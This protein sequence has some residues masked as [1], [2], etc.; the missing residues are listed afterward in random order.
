MLDQLLFGS[1][2]LML[3]VSL[4]LT[5]K[6]RFVQ[7]RKLP[8]MFSLFLNRKKG[9]DGTIC[10]R[11]ALFTAMSTTLGLSTM[12]APVIAIRLGGPGAVMGFFLATVLGA[13][14]SYTE[15]SFA[16]AYREKKEGKIHGGPMQDLQKA[17]SPF[18]AKWYAFFCGI[19]MMVWSAAQSNQ[20]AQL[21]SAKHVCLVYIPTWITG[22][23]LAIFVLIIL[24]GGIKRIASWSAK[25][26]PTMF[27]LYVGA[28]LFIIAL[29]IGK[30]PSIFH[31][32]WSSCFH[33]QSF[34]SG[35]VIGGLLSAFRWGILKGL[36]GNEAG[37]GTQT[38]PHSMAEVDEAT[39]QGIL[40]MA[41]TYC[42][43]VILILSSFVALITMTWMDPE[44][45]LGIEMVAVSFFNY[46]SYAGLVIVSISALLFA[47][48]T[49]LGNSY[50][51]SQCFLYLS[52]NHGIVFY[53][54][55]TAALIFWGAI[56]GVKSLWGN[57][58]FVLA[59]V[60]VP[61]ILSILWLSFRK[62]ES[63]STTTS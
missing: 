53:Y 6:T 49:I 37:I 24:I 32:I 43:G 19:L 20:L 44:L 25:L 1:G 46:F 35:I 40:S 15:V 9:R 10:S 42:A 54:L 52:K 2:I 45:N 26:V 56:A 28:A 34:G 23:V 30:L 63:L 58:D 31:L 17:I 8:Q 47:F 18:M 11:R 12:V 59:L 48:G 27:L 50:N 5:I 21:L 38:I 55:L 4:I 41:S 14:V 33:P 3:T 62:Q 60:M 7:F 29:N 57:I 61:H 36:H 13:A 22:S 39:D 51:G 16:L